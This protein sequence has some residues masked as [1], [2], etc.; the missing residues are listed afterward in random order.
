[1]DIITTEDPDKNTASS[2]GGSGIQPDIV[3]PPAGFADSPRQKHAGRLYKKLEKRFRSEDRSER[4]CYKYRADQ[5]RAKV[6]IIQL[7]RMPKR[8]E[9]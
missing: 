9:W 4:R 2:N 7:V 3:Q 5:V 6:N 1:M 8:L